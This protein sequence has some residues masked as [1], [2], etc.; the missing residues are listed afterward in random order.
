MKLG[1]KELTYDKHGKI[2]MNSV[3]LVAIMC[4]TWNVN[5]RLGE[6]PTISQMNSSIAIAVE[7]HRMAGAH[8]GV[9]AQLSAQDLK[10]NTITI[11]LL[12][13]EIASYVSRI[14]NR[15]TAPNME[16]WRAELSNLLEQYR[17]VSGVSYDPMLLECSG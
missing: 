17:Q 11:L 4:A 8:P 15:P 10:L 5:D 16:A 9:D 6:I 14:C 12:R 3:M 13:G 7:D 1:N 2:S